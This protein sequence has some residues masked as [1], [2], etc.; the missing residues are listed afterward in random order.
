MAIKCD[1]LLTNGI[2]VTMNDVLQVIDEGSVAISGERILAVGKTSELLSYDVQQTIDCKGKMIL[3]GF[4]DCHNHLFQVLARGIGDGLP[5]WTWLSDFMF[6]Y[7]NDITSD[8]AVAGVKISAVEAV[9]NGTTCVVDNHYA[10]VDLDTTIAV[11]DAIEEVGL[12]GVV[13]RGMFGPMNDVSADNNFKYDRIFQYSID[14]EIDITRAAMEAR[15][16]KKVS[17]WPYPENIV[18]CDQDLIRRAIELAREFG[19]GWQAH[20]SETEFEVDV[21]MKTYGVRPIEWLYKEG[22]LGEGATLAHGIWLDDKEIEYVGETQTGISH[23]PVCNQYIGSGPIRLRDL[24]SAGAIVGLGTDGSA[25]STQDM[26]QAIRQCTYIQRLHHLDPA[27][28]TVEEVLTLAT[29]EGARFTGIDAGQLTPGKLA[30][31][32]VISLDGPH[33]VPLNNVYGT[34]AYGSKGSDVDL[35]IIGGEIVFAG[36]H[37]TLV[38]EKEIARDAQIRSNDLIKRISLTRLRNPPR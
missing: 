11:A 2:V 18:Y 15:A 17:V 10:P 16:G 8:E 26:I 3:P 19:S 21:Y 31:V 20:C 12:R 34:L 22:L 27:V 5:L 25:V 36:D 7:A 32:V 33:V 6:P 23:Q 1:L 28:V 4:I 37:C 13:G 29:R 35:T 30:D 14:E 9:R 24:R 38:D